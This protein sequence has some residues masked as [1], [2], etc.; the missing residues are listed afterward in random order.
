MQALLTKTQVGRSPWQGNVCKWVD[1][2]C[3]YFRTPQVASEGSTQSAGGAEN[4]RDQFFT[5]LL[6]SG[7]PGIRWR[8]RCRACPRSRWRRNRGPSTG[9]LRPGRSGAGGPCRRLRPSPWRSPQAD[10][11]AAGWSRTRQNAEHVE[12][13]LACRG[14]GVDRL[15]SSLEC[16]ALGLQSTDDVLKVSYATGEPIDPGGTETERVHAQTSNPVS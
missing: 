5:P 12:E 13:A 1:V 7:A 15:L 3:S 10:V 2:P 6:A 16:H 8:G 9:A 11:H 14:A 4:G